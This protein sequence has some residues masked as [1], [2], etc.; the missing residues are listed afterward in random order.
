ME[1]KE[2]EMSVEDLEKIMKACKPVAMLMLQCG[3]PRSQQANANGAW[4]ELGKR[5]GFDHMTVEPVSGKGD[6]FFT[7]IPKAEEK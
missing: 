2:Y 7:A 3:T 4:E 1:R 5:M 6:S